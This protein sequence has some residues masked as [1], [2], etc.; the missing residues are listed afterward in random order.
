MPISSNTAQA[1]LLSTGHLNTGIYTAQSRS[2]RTHV[3]VYGRTGCGYTRQMIDYLKSQKIPYTFH[4]ID[5]KKIS[6][7]LFTQM[8]RAGINQ[9]SYGLPIVELG[10]KFFIQPKPA[11]I[12]SAYDRAR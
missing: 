7:K 6:S 10:G 4:S 8:Q 3:N 12:R 11:T 9:N 2:S 5:D 1:Q